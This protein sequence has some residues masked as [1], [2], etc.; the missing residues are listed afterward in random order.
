MKHILTILLLL[1]VSALSAQTIKANFGGYADLRVVSG[2]G[3]IYTFDLNGFMGNPRFQVDGP[4]DATAVQVGDV[5]W[6]DCARF[7]VV[8]VRSSG[9]STLSVDVQ[10]PA[11]DFAMG[12]G[13]PPTNSR[14]AVV[15]EFTGDFPTLPPSGDGNNGAL[16][17]IDNNLWTCMY[18]HYNTQL[19][20][21][22][23]TLNEITEYIG[24]TDVAP[25]VAASGYTGQL[26]KNSVGQIYR[27]DGVSWIK[28]G[29]ENIYTVKNYAIAKNISTQA[30]F[31]A[32]KSY[33]NTRGGNIV[34]D[35]TVTLTTNNTVAS[36]LTLSMVKGGR[37]IIPTATTLTINGIFE[38]PPAQQ[39]FSWTGTGTVLFAQSS[40]ATVW[41]YW[42][43]AKNDGATDCQPGIQ[44]AINVAIASTIKHVELL[45]GIHVINKGLV[46]KDPSTTVT[47][48]L[49]GQKAYDYIRGTNITCR[50]TNSFGVGIQGGRAV[51][52]KGIYFQGRISTYNPTLA[53]CIQNTPQQWRDAYGR[54]SRYSP[55]AAIVIEPFANTIPPDGGYPGFTDEYTAAN[56]GFSSDIIIED[57]ICR[58][59]IVGMVITPS[60]TTGNGA[61]VHISE[62]L[63]DRCQYGLSTCQTQSRQINLIAS[64]TVANQIS[65]DGATFGTRLGVMPNSINCQFG[66]CKDI[67][68]FSAGRGGG[69]MI[70]MY[71]ESIYRLGTW[72]GF[73]DVLNFQNC[74]F[75]MTTFPESGVADAASILDAQSQINFL[76]GSITY[77]TTRPIEMRVDNGIHFDGTR[78]T[79]LV[80]NHPNGSFTSN[81]VYYKNCKL[82][83]LAGEYNNRIMSDYYT[84][85]D[86]GNF[87]SAIYVSGFRGSYPEYGGNNYVELS[88]ARDKQD[89]TIL[90]DNATVVLNNTLKTATF[91]TTQPGKYRVGDQLSSYNNNST[92]TPQN[93]NKACSFGVVTSIVGN[94]VTCSHIPD[95]IVGGTYGIYLFVP[96]FNVPAHRASIQAGTNKLI[97]TSKATNRSVTQFWPIGTRIYTDESAFNYGIYYGLHITSIVADTIYLSGNSGVTFTDIE[98]YSA[99]LKSTY[100][101]YDG[102]YPTP[103]STYR[104]VGFRKGDK[105]EFKA[106]PYL[107][108]AVVT[109]GG[110]TPDLKFNFKRVSGTT[111]S[112]PTPTAQEEGLEYYN[113]TLGVMQ[114]WTGAAWV[115]MGTIVSAR[116]TGSGTVASPL[117]IAPQGASNGQVLKFNGTNWVP[118]NDNVGS[119]TSTDLQSTNTKITVVNGTGAVLGSSPVTLTV[120]EANLDP[121]ALPINDVGGYFPTDNVNAALQSLGANNHV[122]VTVTD[123]S[124][125]DLTLTGQNITAS[126]L[127]S[128]ITA[129][130]IL[131]GTVGN[132]ELANNSIGFG[133]FANNSATNGQVIQ[134]NGT[135]WVPATITTGGIKRINS[136]VDTA[137]T[138]VTGAL[139]TD[140]NISSTGG[141]HTFNLPVA[142]GTKTGKLS[143]TDWTNF[144][145][146][147]GGSG[148]TDR[149]P[150]FSGASTLTSSPSIFQTGG[151][152]LTIGDYTLTAGAE[153]RGK[154]YN[155][156]GGQVIPTGTQELFSV[157]FTNN[158]NTANDVTVRGARFSA[159]LENTGTP[160]NCYVSGFSSIASVGNGTTSL[161]AIYGGGLSVSSNSPN[162]GQMYG[163]YGRLDQNSATTSGVNNLMRFDA[164]KS[165]NGTA[166]V[167]EGVNIDINDFNPVG[168]WQQATGAAYS[169]SNAQTLFGARYNIGNTKGAGNS[170]Y[171]A[172]YVMSASGAGVV[173]NNGY[174]I[175]MEGG[176]SSGATYTNF[177]GFAMGAMNATNAWMLYNDQSIKSYHKGNFG[178]GAGVSNPS[179]ALEVAGNIRFSGDLRPNNLPGTTGQWLQSTGANTP[180]IWRDANALFRIGVPKVTPNRFGATFVG[181]SLSLERCSFLGVGIIDT[182]TQGI[183]GRKTFRH[184]GVGVTIPL[185]IA[186]NA[187]PAE[188]VRTPWHLAGAAAMQVTVKDSISSSIHF[189]YTM[190]QQK[191]TAGTLRN[192]L[193][194]NGRGGVELH[195]SIAYK[196]RV[197]SSGTS[198]LLDGL[199][200]QYSI[201]GTVDTIYLPSIVEEAFPGTREV[202]IGYRIHLAN[203]SNGKVYVFTVG[204]D[205]V[206]DKG[207]TRFIIPAGGNV[208][209]YSTSRTYWAANYSFP[210]ATETLANTT[211]DF[212]GANPFLEVV[213]T[214]TTINLPE[215]VTSNPGPNEVLVGTTFTIAIDRSVNVTINRGGSSDVFKRNGDT[216]SGTS[217]VTTGGTYSVLTYFAGS[218]DTWY[219]K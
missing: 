206:G 50:D 154:L 211:I 116:L 40:V 71:G 126:V 123:G 98:I 163:F 93:L 96:K 159:N 3:P 34:V 59:F 2:T 181:D 119:V 28:D 189:P 200:S 76:G 105:I 78:L 97:V 110:F 35:T 90:I 213:S 4:Y 179:E 155:V 19:F 129:T 77:S 124:Q 55:Y 147:I 108:S 70:N 156:V 167:I 106:H 146:K 192:M 68:N 201:T 69:K 57:V 125:I 164:R 148:V 20:T 109:K 52:I 114:Y 195:K 212:D 86:V 72:S 83:G 29:A 133:K 87:P 101:S 107:E 39:C 47:L 112:R 44:K 141:V 210:H 18:N 65:M 64:G 49:K 173:V 81:A 102:T 53:Q 150:Y 161:T 208:D 136:Q 158:S 216:S 21:T 10:I 151:K 153:I 9:F 160:T 131:D 172:T 92:S 137:Q 207:I 215:I 166:H 120:N 122:P 62:T 170:Q 73:G 15:R 194:F 58:Y 204:D 143:S 84:A 187:D 42:F 115:E 5:I 7:V 95:G 75:N 16:T 184:N 111:G 66:Y 33:F 37:F 140:F 23:N 11:M 32:L 145:N 25:A 138:L 191:T 193:M 139:G 185:I 128:S 218:E 74:E 17:G 100:Y 144:T 196:Q 31:N 127:P 94:T 199:Q 30:S 132:S 104:N 46:I 26:W 99:P 209:L 56:N 24:A 171:G 180:P 178:I 22:V 190:W 43:G 135:S 12:A 6:G 198:V 188:G 149:V 130:E 63:F 38:A 14:V 197:Y 79:G 121:T 89:Y 162:V 103:S 165:L 142:D 157:D 168:R 183:N 48:E 8:L 1:T 174:G 134:F 88:D 27:S 41:P 152:K 113:T 202:T 13:P 176:A 186:N 217:I 219:V 51:A 54:N 118:A 214:T 80:M 60:G 117:D 45:S 82:D 36:N 85:P 205:N 177:Y 203:N 182:T 169:V 175:T 61:E 91:T 67:L